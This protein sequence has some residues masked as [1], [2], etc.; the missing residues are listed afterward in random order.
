MLNAL[1]AV[2]C[3]S[4]AFILVLSGAKKLSNPYQ[5]LVAVFSWKL[6]GVRT[7][8]FFARLYPY[9]ELMIGVVLTICLVFFRRGLAFS[10]ALAVALAMTLFVG[11]VVAFS[12]ARGSPCGC[13]YRGRLGVASLTKVVAFATVS[14]AGAV[15]AALTS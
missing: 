6:F 12:R 15:T 3:G 5:W 13:G 1:A 2:T 4:T 10:S 14:A 8:R 7:G 11:H 9:A